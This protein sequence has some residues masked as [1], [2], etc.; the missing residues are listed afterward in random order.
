M[1][2]RVTDFPTG[3]PLQ[4]SIPNS[5][6]SIKEEIATLE[7]YIQQLKTY[8]HK[9]KDRREAKCDF[10]A[11]NKENFDY[12]N[13]RFVLMQ[14]NVMPGPENNGR[15]LSDSTALC[16]IDDITVIEQEIITSSIHSSPDTSTEFKPHAKSDGLQSPSRGMKGRLRKLKTIVIPSKKVLVSKHS[17]HKRSREQITKE[18]SYS[19]LNKSS[20][21]GNTIILRHL[22]QFSWSKLGTAD[23]QYLCRLL[24]SFVNHCYSRQARR[25][26]LRKLGLSQSSDG[27]FNLV[28][29]KFNC[30]RL[31]QIERTLDLG[32][33]T[34]CHKAHL[35]SHFLAPVSRLILPE[36]S[37]QCTKL[38][39]E[40]QLL[41]T[42]VAPVSTRKSLTARARPRSGLQSGTFNSRSLRRRKY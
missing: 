26:I 35:S 28:P 1:S 21:N 39:R 23:R 40:F 20:Y 4:G 36:Y 17:I 30:N 41:D 10:T 29:E 31:N 2:I 16:S 9:I 5:A 42:H 15:E 19:L 3:P 6:N 18:H 33:T 37:K 27:I 7:L 38:L 22:G 12:S 25:Q 24:N 34:C 13:S 32:K 8:R 11:K 14:N